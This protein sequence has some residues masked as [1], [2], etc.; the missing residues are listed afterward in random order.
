MDASDSFSKAFDLASDCIG[1]RFQNP[2]YPL[3]ELFNGE[4]HAAFEEVRS[5]GQKIVAKAKRTRSLAAFESLIDDT[6]PTFDTTLINLLIESLGDEDL[7]AEASLN[8]LSAGKDTT[9][10]ALTWTLYALLRHPESWVPLRQ[11]VEYLKGVQA[12]DTLIRDQQLAIGDLQPTK[13]P[14][15]MATLYEGLRLFP[16]IPIEIQE[17][18][19]ELTLPD[20]T[21]LPK[22]SVI[23]YSIW[24]L[25]RARQIYG[26][27]AE[28]FKPSRWLNDGKFVAKSASE[29]PVF[30]G[31]PRMCLGK[32][33]AELMATFCLIN[34]QDFT[35]ELAP[36]LSDFDP[37]PQNSLTLPMNGGL[38]CLVKAR[39]G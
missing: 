29:F 19:T 18:R 5:F 14:L 34:L 30:N 15:H 7:V 33:M 32:K 17:A 6:E 13:I 21:L 12:D 27:D 11:E 36:F 37:Q 8:F 31:G 9:A 22:G 3:T 4:L 38:P 39:S 26:D 24:A 25:N 1:R 23:V 20:G 28:S 2:L 16:P 35:F 10:Q